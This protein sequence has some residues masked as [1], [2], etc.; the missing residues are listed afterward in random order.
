M[1]G[2]FI[3]SEVKVFV[4]WCIVVL[5]YKYVNFR[6]FLIIIFSICIIYVVLNIGNIKYVKY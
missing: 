6:Y 5:L 1:M 4:V 2:S 3:Y